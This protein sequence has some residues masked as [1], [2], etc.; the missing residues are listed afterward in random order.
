[1][2]PYLTSIVG[3]FS[4]V[5]ILLFYLANLH[6]AQNLSPQGCRMSWMSPSYVLQNGFD[7]SWSPLARRYSLWL[8][9]EVGWD[10][11]QVSHMAP[12]SKLSSIS[13]LW[14]DTRCPRL[15]HTRQCRIISSSTV[16]C[17]ICNKAILFITSSCCA[18]ILFR[19]EASGF[20]C[21]YEMLSL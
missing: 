21:R 6:V 10:S 17:I 19:I 16:Y 15:V 12:S 13:E 3:V 5:T 4:L 14:K 18:G 1:M 11:N 2:A 8:Y 20:L 9:R 7:S